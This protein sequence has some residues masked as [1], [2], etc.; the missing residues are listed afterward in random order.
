MEASLKKSEYRV[1][2]FCALGCATMWGLLPIYWHALRPIDSF[3][4]IFYRIVLV[5]LTTFLAA[6]KL[7]GWEKIKAPLKQ[8]KMLFT[9]IIA[10]I[11]ITSNWSIY[12][13]A[14]NADLVIQTCI[15]YYIEPLM[16]CLFGIFLF[17]EKLTKYKLVALGFAF[18]GVVVVLIHFHEIPL[19]ALSLALTFAVYAAIK[20]KYK[21]EALISLF[22]ET[23]FLTPIALG[24]VIYFEVTGRGAF[25][26][27]QPHQFVL[28]AII[29]IVTAIP[30]ALFAM[31]ANRVSLI[32]LGITEYISPSIS[33]LLSIFFFREP[34]DRI[35][36]ISFVIIW[37]GLLYFTYGEAREVKE[38]KEQNV[39]E[40]IPIG[41]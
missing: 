8:K 30:L 26:V 4:I 25:S 18:A 3:V 6:Y 22:Y 38:Y 11:L 14:V 41:E 31:A 19:I 12:I 7:H 2:L 32:T 21:V 23:V 35:Q 33:L 34:F 40:S 29:G 1:G 16:V 39:L 9:F 17:K 5:G 24:M 10:G 37:I 36:L 15:G 20:K 28:L 27:A 13:W